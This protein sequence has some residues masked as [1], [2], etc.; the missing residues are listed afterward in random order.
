MKQVRSWLYPRCTEWFWFSLHSGWQTA[1]LGGPGRQSHHCA[2]GLEEGGEAVCH[3]VSTI[4]LEHLETSVSPHPKSFEIMLILSSHCFS[5]F[6]LNM[7]VY[8]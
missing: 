8:E 4:I 2:V 6:S 7:D 1:R 3:A 5:A